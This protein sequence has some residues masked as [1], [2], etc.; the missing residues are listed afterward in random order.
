[1]T[2]VGRSRGLQPDQ[3]KGVAACR[4]STLGRGLGMCKGPGVGHSDVLRVWLE[5]RDV[6][7]GQTEH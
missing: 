4:N 6:E 3:D 7:K 5:L 1:M 2:S